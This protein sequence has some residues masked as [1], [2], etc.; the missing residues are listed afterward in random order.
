MIK[1][2]CPECSQKMESGTSIV[3]GTFTGFLFVGF[4][5]QHLFFKKSKG[6]K[7]MIVPSNKT[8]DAYRCGECGITTLKDTEDTGLFSRAGR[9][10]G[11]K[12]NLLKNKKTLTRRGQGLRAVDH[13]PP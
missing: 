12:Y 7:E 2:I 5:Y 1:M 10:L 3:E 11:K 13:T 9:S 6:K 4:S 8:V